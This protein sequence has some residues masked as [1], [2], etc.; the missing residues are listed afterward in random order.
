MKSLYKKAILPTLAAVFSISLQAAPAVIVNPEN[1]DATDSN[2]LSAYLM[3]KRKFW[4]NGSEVTIAVLK[5]DSDSNAALEQFTKMN[6]SR[7]KS[8]WQRL[9]F[10][11]RGTM[12]KQFS[13]P[14]ELVAFVKGH[15][16]AIGLLSD[17]ADLSTVKKVN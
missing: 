3:G 17:S 5:G 10:S 4:E 12:P 2:S 14:A 8:H 11:G 13:D 6:D 7:F 15:K 16:G 9:A 1:A